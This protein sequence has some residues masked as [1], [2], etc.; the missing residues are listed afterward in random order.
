MKKVIIVV[1]VLVVIVG[2]IYAFTQADI[3]ISVAALDGQLEEAI[4][5]DLIIPVSATGTVEASKLIQIKSKAS[6]EVIRIHVVEGEMV[7]AGDVLVELDPVD[8]KRNVEARQ[9][10]KDRASSAME[11]TNIAV[12]NLRRDLP[13]QTKLAEA[14]FAD[15]KAR[16]ENAEY[17]WDRVKGFVEKGVS[18]EKEVVFTRTAF[19]TAKAAMEVAGTDLKRAQNNEEILLRD[20]KENVKQAEAALRVSQKQLDEAS[21]RLEETTVRARSSGMVYGIRIREGEMIQSGTVSF[22]GGT[23]LMT[24][25]DT[26]AMFVMAQID[27]ADIGAIRD[28]APT[29]ARP[30]TT[31]KLTEED[32]AERANKIIQANRE[33]TLN[34][35]NES[36]ADESE[37]TQAEPKTTTDPK[38]G[39]NEAVALS[40]D[41]DLP[42]IIKSLQSRPVDIV[43]EAYRDVKYRGVIERILPEPQRVN[44]AIAFPVRIRLVGDDL[45]KLMGLQADLSFTTEKREGVVKVL[46]EALHSQGRQCFVY[47]PVS[48]QPR[49]EKKVSVEIGMTDGIHTEISEG[50]AAGDMVYT[51]RPI[52][53]DKERRQS[54]D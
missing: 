17:E 5:G 43:V 19:V 32:Y 49:E 20:A 11:K 2:G 35:N 3:G 38:A 41:P 4:L 36:D 1:I 53:T 15:A 54:E 46:N 12:E 25:A 29:Y 42:E 21:L 31:E 40:T 18:M 10:D 23:A 33:N 7:V 52:K 6:G 22:T 30:G 45:E 47:V 16:Y 48:G 13:L 37:G 24:L 8:E 44:N 9:A 39:S 14:R 27:E 51:R 28:I 26:S 50:L 34:D